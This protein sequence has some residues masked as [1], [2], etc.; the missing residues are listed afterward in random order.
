MPGGAGTC[1]AWVVTVP[2]TPAVLNALPPALKSPFT[3]VVLV[4]V[5]SPLDTI[6]PSEPAVAGSYGPSRE[7]QLS[8]PPPPMLLLACPNTAQGN[9]PSAQLKLWTGA[10]AGREAGCAPVAFHG[11][12][13]AKALM[14]DSAT[15]TAGTT[16]PARLASCEIALI[17]SAPRTTR[18]RCSSWRRFDESN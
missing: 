4:R 12:A 2:A 14:S 16:T 3:I 5:Q 7:S 18:V 1:G 13:S 11:T 6:S 8:V 10:G 15:P 17:E 9:S